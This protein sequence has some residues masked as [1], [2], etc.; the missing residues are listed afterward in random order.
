MLPESFFKARNMR[1]GEL[2]LQAKILY[3]I[4]KKEMC[5]RNITECFSYTSIS[6]NVKRY[7]IFQLVAI[8]QISGNNSSS[9]CYL[10][11]I[12]GKYY[13][14]IGDYTQSYKNG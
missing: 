13:Y 11:Y 14:S 2:L 9:A 12:I 10:Q 1:E 6:S 5:K 7:I 4:N 3:F 8:V